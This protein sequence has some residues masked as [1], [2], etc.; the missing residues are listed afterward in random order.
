MATEVD[1][2]RVINAVAATLSDQRL[3][4]FDAAR[5]QEIVTGS[6]GGEQKFVAY[7]SGTSG[8]LREGGMEGPPVARFDFERGEWSAQRIPDSRKSEQLQQ[9]EQQRSKQEE[10][11]YQKPVRGRVAIWKKKLSGG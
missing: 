4:A 11:E 7:G 3:D 2:T 6:L 1:V 5:I 8:E 9:F 10:T